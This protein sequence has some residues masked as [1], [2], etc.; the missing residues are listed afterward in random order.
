LSGRLT[1]VLGILEKYPWNF[2]AIDFLID[3][4]PCS[5]AKLA[6]TVIACR[7]TDSSPTFSEQ[8]PEWRS[9]AHPQDNTML[10]ELSRAP[11]IAQAVAQQQALWMDASYKREMLLNTVA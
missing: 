5:I 7:A 11:T 9:L 4:D 10:A 2:E 3:R 6:P 1:D 8:M